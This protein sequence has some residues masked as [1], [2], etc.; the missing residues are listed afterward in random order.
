MR[1]LSDPDTPACEECGGETF[2]DE[3]VAQRMQQSGKRN[4]TGAFAKPIEMLSVALDD[5]QGIREF[6]QRN[7]DVECSMDRSSPHFGVPMA[8]TRQEKLSVLKNEGFAEN[9]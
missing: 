6:K 2:R 9:N 7:P 3:A 5:E 4:I 8:R 1:S